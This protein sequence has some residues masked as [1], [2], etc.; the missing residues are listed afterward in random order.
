MDEIEFRARDQYNRGRMEVDTI[1][2]LTLNNSHAVS[3]IEDLNPQTVVGK[4]R[5]YLSCCQ[6]ALYFTF[7][8]EH[9]N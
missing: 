4:I 2:F 7:R 1:Y 5:Y 8:E 3:V 6:S 9:T